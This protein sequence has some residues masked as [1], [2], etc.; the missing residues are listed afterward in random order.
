MCQIIK[1]FDIF[2]IS[3]CLQSHTVVS[4]MQAKTFR[5]NEMCDFNFTVKYTLVLCRGINSKH[6][7][8]VKWYVKLKVFVSPWGRMQSKTMKIMSH[9]ECH[10][11]IPLFLHISV[12]K[13][14][15]PYCITQCTI[16][17]QSHLWVL[18]LT[19]RVTWIVF[20]YLVIT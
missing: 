7:A 11:C 13:C 14:W 9:L 17:R 15:Q 6:E 16:T 3:P 2:I 12:K 18:S 8:K 5:S 10:S 20:N 1:L 4:A 19:I